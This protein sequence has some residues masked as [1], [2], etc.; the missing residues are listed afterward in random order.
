MLLL[1]DHCPAA[2]LPHG[3]VLSQ[4]RAVKKEGGGGGLGQTN[5]SDLKALGYHPNELDRLTDN[6]P[7][8]L[9]LC[10]KPRLLAHL[11][12]STHP[13]KSQTAL[14]SPQRQAHLNINLAC[15]PV[16]L[17]SPPLPEPPSSPSTQSPS[18]P[19]Q[20]T[21]PPMQGTSPP[22]QGY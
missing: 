10:Q 4:E 1:P 19:M 6:L 9:T 12:P 21:S 15:T 16:S 13:C 14:S 11:M 7:P 17:F 2:L 8:P 5:A 22:I 20:D 18:P 3:T